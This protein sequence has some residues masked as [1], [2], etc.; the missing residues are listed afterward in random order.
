MRKLF[1]N[2]PV[3]IAV[4]AIIGFL[5]LCAFT[6]NT[7]TAGSAEGLL[8]EAVL[9]VQEFARGL[10]Q[11]VT[12]F[13]A[14]VFNPSTLESE[15][16]SLRREL[17]EYQ[18]REAQYEETSRENARLAELLNYTQ[19]NPNMT[20]L[21]AQVVS[22]SFNEYVDTLTLNVGSRSG[23]TESMAVVTGGG[24]VGRVVEVGATWCKVRTMLNDDMR[25][26]VMVQR[27]RDEGMFGGVISTAGESAV[28]QLY[29]LPATAQ[30]EIGD[31]IITSGLGGTYPKGIYV[32]EVI[33]LAQGNET[34]DALVRIDI[35]FEHLEEALLVLN[36]EEVVSD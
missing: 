33:E 1:K 30:L 23:V 16:E 29:Y 34:Y 25:I 35:D 7:R 22:R 32:G 3:L 17:E 27:S 21:T 11:D 18:L 8:T 15:N 4:I 28:L 13:F 6:L 19:A 31:K 9:P 5:V 20:F 10:T 12:D 2:K 14:R 26:S 36:V 24:V